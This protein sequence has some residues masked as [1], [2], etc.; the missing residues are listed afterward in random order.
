MK[1]NPY[2]GKLRSQLS[3]LTS[4]GP[5]G[6]SDPLRMNSRLHQ[7]GWPLDPFYMLNDG[8]MHKAYGTL[9]GSVF[10]GYAK[11]SHCSLISKCFAG[12]AS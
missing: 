12:D 9:P 11:I 10:S 1:Q 5:L 7:E 4:F 6:I 3:G 8:F 2:L